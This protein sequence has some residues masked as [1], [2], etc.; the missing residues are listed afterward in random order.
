MSIILNALQSG[1][2]QTAEN[3]TPVV[4]ESQ[5]IQENQEEFV[6]VKPGSLKRPKS[7]PPKWRVWVLA[8]AVFLS[9]VWLGAKFWA[10]R[11]PSVLPQED[12]SP[13]VPE[14]SP[15]A[16]EGDQALPPPPEKGSEEILIKAHEALAK[17]Q[18]DEAFKAFQAL[19]QTQPGDYSLHNK[20]GFIYLKKELYSN[21]L[22]SFN[23]A[24]EL[25]SDCAECLNNLGYL[26]S[27]LGEPVEAETYFQKAIQI[28]KDFADPY[29]NL[30]VLWE[31]AG[32]YE[33]AVQYYQKFVEIH[34]NVEDSVI[35]R[36]EDRID[37]L[38][39]K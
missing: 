21:A 4:Q 9:S 8:A 16:P 19:V 26:K 5:N 37:E 32:D 34:P 3:L 17:G 22:Q 24:L 28:K 31:Q 11:K 6:V 30:G 36:V 23:R 15:Q 2:P 14:L 38:F 20:I 39:Q 18:Y 27:I 7:L 29:F 10:G 25:N 33:R 1:E 12:L 13:L 35:E